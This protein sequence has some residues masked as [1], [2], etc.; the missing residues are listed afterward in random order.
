MNSHVTYN[1]F[2][3]GTITTN[4]HDEVFVTEDCGENDL[5]L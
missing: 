2:D 3:P 4:Q 1:N 5:D